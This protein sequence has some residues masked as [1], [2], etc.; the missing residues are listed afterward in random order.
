MQEAAGDDGEV[1]GEGPVPAEEE[2]Q[3][4]SRHSDGRLVVL[5]DPVSSGQLGEEGG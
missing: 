4:D 5:E 3:G 1:V 2:G